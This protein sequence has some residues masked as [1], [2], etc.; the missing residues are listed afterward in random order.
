M[1]LIRSP[2]KTLNAIKW[3]WFFKQLH[4]H[5]KSLKEH[6]EVNELV[7][8]THD[9][10]II[11]NRY[12]MCFLLDWKC[13]Y[14]N[15]YKYLCS[16]GKQLTSAERK[17][18][19]SELQ[20]LTDELQLVISESCVSYQC[21]S[22]GSHSVCRFKGIETLDKIEGSFDIDN[23]PLFTSDNWY[24]CSNRHVMYST[25]PPPNECVKCKE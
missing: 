1:Y 15:L 16:S 24:V 18:F 23:T 3:P 6:G 13:H 2:L 8:H 7:S 20:L 11:W 25:S 14:N 4:H 10:F 21:S 19:L 12:F 5:L 9:H 17:D 22:E